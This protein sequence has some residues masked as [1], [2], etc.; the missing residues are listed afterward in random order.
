MYIENILMFVIA[1]DDAVALYMPDR[2]YSMYVGKSAE[3]LI[4][5]KHLKATIAKLLDIE[6]GNQNG[7]LGNVTLLF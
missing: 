5:I 7:S 3:K 4:W 6:E 1:K 2:P